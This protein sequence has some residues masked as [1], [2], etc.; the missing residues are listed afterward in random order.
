MALFHDWSLPPPPI[1]LLNG[2][3][4]FLDFDGTIIPTAEEPGAIFIGATLHALLD[5]LHRRHAGRI[6]IVS[7]RS[8]AEIR[9]RLPGHDIVIVGSHGL[10][11]GWPDGR[12]LTYAPPPDV[13]RLKKELQALQEAHPGILIEEKPFGVAIH[14]R[15]AARAEAA[16]LK[17]ASQ[18]ALR[19]NLFLQPGKMVF[20]LKPLGANKGTAVE[21]L[22]REPIMRGHAPI[23][24][25][26]DDSDEPGFAAA[27]RLRGAGVLV[28]EPRRTSATYLLSDVTNV[29][30]WLKAK[31]PA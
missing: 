28:G 25:G 21:A 3:A 15:R 8:L 22:M 18:L 17:C 1:E 6:A 10:E 14:F 30:D 5:E 24:I 27:A 29:L 9:Q 23:F 11:I 4:L 19:E 26:D 16:C 13:S 2:A 31:E 20:E 12:R 7:G